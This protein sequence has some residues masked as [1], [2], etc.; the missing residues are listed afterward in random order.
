MSARYGCLAVVQLRAA[1]LDFALQDLGGAPVL[2]RIVARTR[3]AALVDEVSLLVDEGPGAAEVLAWLAREGLAVER[4]PQGDVLA[5]CLALA[6]AHGARQLVRVQGDFP[7][8]DPDHLDLELGALRA[9]DAD[10]LGYGA[11][12]AARRGGPL[13][14]QFCSS[15][16][17]LRLAQ[18]SDDP[19]D[20]L[21][22]GADFLAR[23]VDAF[24]TV[25]L[26]LDARLA[27]P[28]PEL[29]VHSAA[30]LAALR[31]LW[32]AIDHEGDGLFPLGRALRWLAARAAAA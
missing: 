1:H 26:E 19:R 23:H 13:A 15:V 12:E 10:L 3:A 8:V 4:V 7:F 24:R 29:R 5:A 16:R 18:A 11:D 31:V 14:G 2:A 22:A 20:R 32:S 28:G 17:A 6:S 27:R 25:E 30:D 9:F 21:E